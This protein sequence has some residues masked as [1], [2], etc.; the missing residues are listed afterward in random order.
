[1]QKGG[2]AR[3]AAMHATVTIDYI[4]VVEG[5]ITLLLDDGDTV[6]RAGDVLVQGGA[7]HS[8]INHT[9]RPVKILGVLVGAAR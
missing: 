3:H 5:E 6:L 2:S 4:Y 9:D 7:S 1:M 8:W